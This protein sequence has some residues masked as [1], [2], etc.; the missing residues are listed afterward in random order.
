MGDIFCE[1]PKNG[2]RLEIRYSQ[3]F[4]DHI[5]AGIERLTCIADSNTRATM[6]S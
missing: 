2:L 4:K 1:L 6:E 5:L 3:D